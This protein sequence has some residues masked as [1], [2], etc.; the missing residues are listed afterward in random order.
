M[1]IHHFY[2]LQKALCLTLLPTTHMTFSPTDKTKG[3]K[4]NFS[5]SCLHS[6]RSCPRE[7]CIQH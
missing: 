4:G 1:P 3:Q 6:S 5:L 7:D 2:T